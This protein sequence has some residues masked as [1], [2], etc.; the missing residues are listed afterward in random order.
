MAL[1]LLF[2]RVLIQW[3]TFPGIVLHEWSHVA[4]CSLTGTPIHETCYF[5]FGN[6]AGWVKHSPPTNA[7]KQILIGSGPFFVNSLSA[8]AI[9][10]YLHITGASFSNLTPLSTLFIWLGISIGSHSFPSSG[11]ARSIWAGVWNNNT[12]LLATIVGVPIVGLLYVAAVMEFFFTD[13]IY[14]VFLVIFFPSI[15]TS[16]ILIS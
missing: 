7:W 14:G 8:F 10:L 11:D 1:V 12:S 16:C 4:F 15:I 3:A 9:G 6:P 13:V 2:I 5:C